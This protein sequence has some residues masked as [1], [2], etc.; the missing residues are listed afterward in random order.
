MEQRRARKDFARPKWGGKNS[1]FFDATYLKC[2][3]LIFGFAFFASF[4]PQVQSVRFSL[5]FAKDKKKKSIQKNP[6]KTLKTV[7]WNERRKVEMKKKVV[8][9]EE[10]MKKVGRSTFSRR[11]TESDYSKKKFINNI[12][13]VELKIKT[14]DSEEGVRETGAERRREPKE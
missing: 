2:R 3:K 4:M 14:M 1:T 6:P 11:T 10:G 13:R 5:S 12:K 9:G 8:G 7:A